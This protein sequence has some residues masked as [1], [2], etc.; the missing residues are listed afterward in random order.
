[1]PALL[2][3]AALRLSTMH[4]RGVSDDVFVPLGIQRLT[5][6]RGLLEGAVRRLSLKALPPREEEGLLRCGSVAAYDEAGRPR[7]LL[8]GGIARC[9]S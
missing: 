8:E 6:D 2:L 9:L 5:F 1:M 4:V 3:D 7:L